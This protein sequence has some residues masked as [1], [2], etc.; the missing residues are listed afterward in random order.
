MHSF[1]P[2]KL[3]FFVSLFLFLSSPSQSFFFLL[4]HLFPL[5]LSV[6]C[7]IMQYPAEDFWKTI[8]GFESNSAGSIWDLKF[9][10][11]SFSNIII[12][13]ILYSAKIRRHILWNKGR[14]LLELYCTH[15]WIKIQIVSNLSKLSLYISR[16][17][18]ESFKAKKRE[19]KR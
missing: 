2:S 9:L 8:Q 17:A 13:C 10:K 14:H 5:P 7:I 18:I 6:K 16:V 19:K 15:G 12:L 4:F 11:W 3:N 1:P